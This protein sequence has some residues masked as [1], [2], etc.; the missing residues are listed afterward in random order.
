MIIGISGK[1]G[2]GKDT[3]A[4]I[5]QYLLFRANKHEVGL[6]NSFEEFREIINKEW[7]KEE[8]IIETSF[9][10]RKFADKLKDI[11]C[12]LI[13]CTREQ[14]E[15]RE[16]KEKELGEEWWYWYM[17]LDSGYK[18]IILDY[19]STSKEELSNYEG[20]ELIKPTPRFL[21]QQIGTNLFRNQLHPNIWVT[22]LFNDYKER[23]IEKGIGGFHDV[24][25]PI[26]KSIGF[27]KWIITDVRFPNEVKAIKKRDGI[28]IRV[29]RDYI[30][31]GGPEDPKLQHPSEIALDNYK[32]WD[33]VI[34]N[35]GT[36]EDLIEK[37]KEILIKEKLI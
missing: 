13:D 34:E 18:D 5:I 12:M 19:L 25:I 32:D 15:D 9:E 21:L 37:V 4:E 22:S 10:I 23:F 27:P 28:T 3:V 30:L 31:T 20:L 36:I 14:L 7:S 1:I 17:K 8:I 26:T 35:D 11:V 33:Y 16:F 29:N 24:R 2:S 6:D